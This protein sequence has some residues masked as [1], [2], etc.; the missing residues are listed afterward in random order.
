MA[1]S[2]KKPRMVAWLLRDISQQIF[3]TYFMKMI[4]HENLP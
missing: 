2:R 3:S 1:L 4:K